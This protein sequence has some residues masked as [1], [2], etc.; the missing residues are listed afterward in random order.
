MIV[1]GKAGHPNS[2]RSVSTHNYYYSSSIYTALHL[3]RCSVLDPH[4]AVPAAS[5]GG[6]AHAGH[7]GPERSLPGTLPLTGGRLRPP[8]R[9]FLG[10]EAR[11][12]GRCEWGWAPQSQPP[13]SH[14]LRGQGPERTQRSGS[15]DP[16]PAAPLGPRL[17]RQV[18][19]ATCPLQPS[20]RKPAPPC[21]PSRQVTQPRSNFVEPTGA[22]ESCE[23]RYGWRTGSDGVGSWA[24]RR[25]LSCLLCDCG[26]ITSPLWAGLSSI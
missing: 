18:G 17:L 21:S 20:S 25:L 24:H 12:H 10:A 1:G 4:A 13:P 15:P 23:E 2:C 5:R 11:G 26:H 9:R 8:S 7:R 22:A 3:P 14:V 19:W 16:G 6:R